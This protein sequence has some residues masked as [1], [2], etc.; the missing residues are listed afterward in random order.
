MENKEKL[1]GTT[2]R[3]NCVHC[4]MINDA[5]HRQWQAEGTMSHER[6]NR[7]PLPDNVGMHIDPKDGRRIEKITEGSPAAKAGLAVGDEITHVTRQPITSIADI[8]WPLNNL[9]NEDATF[10]LTVVRNGESM[11]KTVSLTKG[12][13]KTDIGWRGSRWSLR[14][15]P[16]FWAP[17]LTDKDIKALGGLVPAGAKPI[18]VQYMNGGKPQP[19]ANIKAGLKVGDVIVALDGKPLTMTPQEFQMHVRM[20]YKKGDTLPVTV[21]R[22]GKTMAF[23]LPLVE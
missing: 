6:L 13:K 14:P 21:V 22:N 1:A 16:G 4:H 5:M 20:N 8:Q 3:N 2:A 7:W 23:E 11:A 17:A 18:R 10:D 15:E 19:N 12:W 9:P